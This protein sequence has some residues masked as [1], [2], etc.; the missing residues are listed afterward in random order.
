MFPN[1]VLQKVSTAEI[2]QNAR[3]GT[4]VHCLPE[5]QAPVWV[6]TGFACYSPFPMLASAISQMEIGGN[7]RLVCQKAKRTGAVNGGA[8]V[9]LDH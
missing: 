4:A 2:L 6:L 8:A 5:W 9:H 7:R 3:V 1:K